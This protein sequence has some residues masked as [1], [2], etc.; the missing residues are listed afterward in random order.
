M[1]EK[2]VEPLSIEDINA[3]IKQEVCHET[4][5]A[6]TDEALI[7]QYKNT[8]S[9]KK[10]IQNL[11]EVLSEEG[12]DEE[13]QKRIIKNFLLKLVPAGTKGNLRGRKFNEITEQ[14]ITDLKLHTHSFEIAFEKKCRAFDTSE[15][16]DWYI[17]EKQTNKIIIGMNQLDLWGG[18]QQSNR[19]SKYIN[20]SLPENIKLLCV[21]C[22]D[23]TIKSKN[24]K[25]FKLFKTGFEN[26][27]LCYLKNLSGIITR[28]FN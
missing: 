3:R 11:S 22:N 28:F 1:S 14:V 27:T 15:I 25:A 10:N 9:V 26:D 4:I 5:N 12:L 21:V 7:T 6:L 16:P 8:K 13:T 17:I 2:T 24:N 23:I 19:G 18:G 20:S